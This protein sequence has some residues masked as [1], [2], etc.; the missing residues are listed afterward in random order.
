MRNICITAVCPRS[1]ALLAQC[2][3]FAVSGLATACGGCDPTDCEEFCE[4]AYPNGEAQI[5]ACRKDCEEEAEACR[6]R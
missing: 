1:F 6:D 3:L 2:G 4:E 5:D